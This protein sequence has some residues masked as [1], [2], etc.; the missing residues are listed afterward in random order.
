MKLKSSTLISLFLLFTFIGSAF[1]GCG[2][3]G[4]NSAPAT[5]STSAPSSDLDDYRMPT[6][7]PNGSGNSQNY[8]NTGGGN[9]SNSGSPVWDHNPS[10]GTGNYNGLIGNAPV[11]Q[12]QSNGVAMDVE[13]HVRLSSQIFLIFGDHGNVPSIGNV[14]GPHACYLIAGRGPIIWT[15]QPQAGEFGLISWPARSKSELFD[16]DSSADVYAWA[17]AKVNALKNDPGYKDTCAKGVD[18]YVLK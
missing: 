2:I 15:T 4:N 16:V 10:L 3:F 5:Q 13:L 12:N 11:D 7:V 9:S 8:G 1:S 6:D 17:A 14:G 18:V